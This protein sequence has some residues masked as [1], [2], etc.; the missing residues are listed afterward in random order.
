MLKEFREF[1]ARG[2]VVDLAVAVVIGAAFNQIV[3]SLVKDIFTPLIGVAMGGLDF[4][5][6]LAF[7]VG[8]AT[9]KYGEFIQAI[10]NFLITAFAMF[11]IVKVYNR[12]RRKEDK[13]EEVKKEVEPSQ[14][15]V[16]LT[17]IRDA[18]VTRTPPA[19]S[20]GPAAGAETGPAADRP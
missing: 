13:K 18:L 5:K 1:L 11:L 6:N 7:T 10:I 16:L 14:E 8:S 2:N 3:N 20:P 12:F 15:V 19:G 17:Q 4:V 9:I